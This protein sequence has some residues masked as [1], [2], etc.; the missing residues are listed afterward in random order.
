[1]GQCYAVSM[2]YKF[3][4]ENGLVKA[5]NDY[6]K[7]HNHK[8]CEFNLDKWGDGF[9]FNRFGNL[10]RVFYSNAGSENQVDWGIF[11]KAPKGMTENECEKKHILHYTDS[12]MVKSKKTG[13]Y[14]LKERLMIRVDRDARGF[15]HFNSGFDA[16]YGWENVLVDAFYVMGQYLEDGSELSIDMDEG[17]R[18]FKVKGGKVEEE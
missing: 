14:E 7:E 13:K 4:D 1:M 8:D 12:K 16:S 6:I 15:Q 17:S 2:T 9:D 18:E 5:L 11:V 3:K 10:M